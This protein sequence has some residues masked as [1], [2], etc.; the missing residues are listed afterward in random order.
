MGVEEP[1]KDRGGRF[2]DPGVDTSKFL[3]LPEDPSVAGPSHPDKD[4]ERHRLETLNTLLKISDTEDPVV[5]SMCKL[6]RSLMRV[7]VAGSQ[8]LCR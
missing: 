7:P 6:L 5:M 4:A 3:F 2:V 8:T 1:V